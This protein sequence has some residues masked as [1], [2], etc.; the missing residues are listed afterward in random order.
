MKIEGKIRKA[1]GYKIGSVLL[2]H[3]FGAQKFRGKW[4][5][6]Y[7][8]YIDRFLTGM[9]VK[10][11]KQARWKL[12]QKGYMKVRQAKRNEGRV[13]YECRI[14]RECL[15]NISRDFGEELFGVKPEPKPK[16]EQEEEKPK[17]RLSPFILGGL[18]VD[19]CYD[20]TG[21]YKAKPDWH[22][23]R[24]E[25]KAAEDWWRKVWEE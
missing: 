5:P 18:G 22:P 17:G 3:M 20:V 11:R 10:E 15:R 13:D 1:L 7:T 21:D 4:Q 2:Y 8:P 14:D 16:Q 12:E 23:K 19:N 9:S 6:Y 24:D 25:E